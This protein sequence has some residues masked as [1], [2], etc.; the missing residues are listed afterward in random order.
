MP[1]MTARAI[2]PTMK[3]TMID[4]MMCNLGLC[5]LRRGAYHG[6]DLESQAF[7]VDNR[8]LLTLAIRFVDGQIFVARRAEGVEHAR[9]LDRLHPM[10][11]MARQVN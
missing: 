5:D 2:R 6:D 4:Q 10:R 3:P 7:S 9:F 8:T 1:G 11:N